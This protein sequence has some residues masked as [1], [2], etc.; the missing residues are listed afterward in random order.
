MNDDTVTE[1]QCS[2]CSGWPAADRAERRK[3]AFDTGYARMALK[4]VCDFCQMEFW[5][6]IAVV[7][8]GPEEYE[9]FREARRQERCKSPASRRHGHELLAEIRSK[10][11]KH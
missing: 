6:G 2:I 10:A 9:A 5:R 1:D 8:D 11:A 4:G 7:C 3:D